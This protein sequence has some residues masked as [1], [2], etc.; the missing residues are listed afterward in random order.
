MVSV[1]YY[2]QAEIEIVLE[3][4]T[5]LIQ[6]IP[7]I[8]GDLLMSKHD[9]K[10]LQQQLK[11]LTKDTASVSKVYGDPI[12]RDGVTVIPLARVIKGKGRDSKQAPSVISPIGYLQVKN[13]EVR[14]RGLFNPLLVA[15]IVIGLGAII[16]FTVVNMRRKEQ[17]SQQLPADHPF[18]PLAR[19]RYLNLTT[20]RKSGEGV[21]TPIWFAENNGTLYI[22][23]AANSGKV[24]R[25]RRT[26]Q[27]KL[28]PSTSSGKPVGESIEGISRVV[29]DPQELQLAEKTLAER[30]GLTYTVFHFGMKVANALRRTAEPERAYLA[31]EPVKEQVTPL[32]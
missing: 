28:T 26:P 4:T 14:Y 31:I 16:G 13:G 11:K 24:K 8:T 10:A 29:Q 23:T 19:F 27:V 6:A 18:Q 5:I 9:T 1:H 25:I 7:F 15:Q 17:T 21:D 2:L 20:F 12:E 22:T 32:A 30:Y 3:L